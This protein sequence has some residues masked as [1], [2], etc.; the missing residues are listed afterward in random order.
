VSI[1]PLTFARLGALQPRLAGLLAEAQAHRRDPGPDYCELAT[2]CGWD[3]GPGF[4]GRLSGLVGC[5]APA[6]APALL[7]SARAD[8]VAYQEILGALPGCRGRCGCC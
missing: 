2:W 4:K 8:D 5:H 6:A 1:K 3:G 7:R